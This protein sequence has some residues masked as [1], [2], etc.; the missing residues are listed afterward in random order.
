[1]DHAALV[2]AILKRGD[3]TLAPD[4]VA[5]LEAAPADYLPAQ[6]I[7]GAHAFNTG[8]MARAV[9]LTRAVFDRDPTR[10]NAS[11][12]IS[13]LTR[14]G[15][16]DEAIARARDPAT[17]IPEVQRASHLSEL[18][19]RRGDA[20]ENRRWSIRAL[21]L[22][23]AEAPVISDRP[24]PVTRPFDPERPTRNIISYALWGTDPRYLEGAERNAIVARHLYPGWTP[25]FYI[26]D[27]V[28]AAT[29]R[30]LGDNGAQLRM[31]P[32]LPARRF[33][34]FWRFLVEDDPEVDLY[35]VRDAD[36]V[37]SIRERVAVR[38]WL[39]SGRPFH[40][41]RDFA[42]HSELVLAGLWGA[43]RGNLPPMGKR[44]L[45][46]AREREKVLNSRVDDQLFLRRAVWPYMRGRAFVQ[47]SWFGYGETAP[48]DPDYPLPG[49][50]H[51]G[52]DD[53][54]HR[55]ATRRNRP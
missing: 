53:Y 4:E 52:Q 28:P 45:A 24:D 18:H 26:D 1:M 11:N 19:G 6:R 51:V 55:H 22:K 50:M 14:A 41:M 7:L 31:V 38:D 49:R 39:A 46:F 32:K 3:L 40:V 34:L 16:V 27:S 21:E 25:R 5:V 15:R 29:R 48:F 43:H 13:A 2:D 54:T 44:I 17:P 10:E 47:D 30:V 8:D 9:D 12:L 23:D 42:T 37:P 36:S 33:G 20:E 35:V